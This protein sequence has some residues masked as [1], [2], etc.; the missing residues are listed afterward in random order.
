MVWYG[1]V[2]AAQIHMESQNVP[3]TNAVCN[4]LIG[5]STLN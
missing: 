1:A 4:K 3:N 2:I 5:C